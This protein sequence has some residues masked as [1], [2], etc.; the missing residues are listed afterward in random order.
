MLIANI[1]VY[2]GMHN[3]A[4]VRSGTHNASILKNRKSQSIATFIKKHPSDIVIFILIIVY[5]LI[6]LPWN[7]EGKKEVIST[8]FKWRREYQL[9]TSKAA[10]IREV[11]KWC[12]ENM[13][14][15]KGNNFPHL[16]ISYYKHKKNAGLYDSYI[17]MIRINV[18]NHNNVLELTDTIIHEYQ[19]HLDMPTQKQQ[20]EYNELTVKNGYWNNPYEIKARESG[21]K[22]RDACAK[23]LF[24]KGFLVIK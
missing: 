19:H 20:K 2:A 15:K 9:N 11:L 14:T 18:N 5:I 3:K 24:K 7:Q 1:S 4:T 16:E 17:K 13:N 8:I 23:E 10:Y 6:L 22:L 12:V 21:L